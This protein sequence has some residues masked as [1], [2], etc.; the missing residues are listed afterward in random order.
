MTL[1][2]FWLLGIPALSVLVVASVMALE[3]I[4]ARLEN[5][6]A[7]WQ[8]RFAASREDAA[9]RTA[10]EHD[11]AGFLQWLSAQAGTQ[12]MDGAV[13]EA[14]VE[15]QRQNELIQLLI[16]R[17]VPK[18]VSQCVRTHR[19]TA[20]VTGA[21]H[22]AHVK[23]EPECHA[24]RARCVWLLRHTA[25]LVQA[26]PFKFDDPAVLHN[27]IVLRRQALPTCCNCP[28]VEYPVHELPELCP[29]ARLFASQGADHAAH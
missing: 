3:L 11:R 13:D 19:V 2:M 25:E 8:D 17:E 20:Q 23:F 9:Q 14:V 7:R 27:A 28:Y 12:Q 24:M 1:L 21:W 6:A 16:D 18:A 15:A 26:Y 4:C 10:E 22:M 29:T 5:A